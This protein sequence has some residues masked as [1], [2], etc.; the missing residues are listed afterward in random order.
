LLVNAQLESLYICISLDYLMTLQ[1]FFVSGLPS[2]N[3]ETTKTA[4]VESDKSRAKTDKKPSSATPKT[5][6]EGIPILPKNLLIQ[7]LFHSSC[8]YSAYNCS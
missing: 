5:P 7:K 2:G 6:S 3:N 1:D 4:L 8:N